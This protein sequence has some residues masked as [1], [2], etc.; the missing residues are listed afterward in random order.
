MR[1]ILT[2]LTL[3]FAGPVFAQ[4]LYSKS[5]EFSA[6][7]VS[8]AALQAVLDKA[9][10]LA[11]SANGGAKPEREEITLRARELR[12]NLPGNKLIASPAKV[13][14]QIDQLTYSF[15]GRA[16][17]PIVQLELDLTEYRR[18][19]TVRGS[20]ADQVDALFAAISTELAAMSHPIGGGVLQ[21]LLG[22]PM[23]LT[24][25]L[26]LLITGWN[27]Y[28]TRAVGYGAVAIATLVALVI[29]ATLPLDHLLAGFLGVRGEP[30][31]LVRYGAEISF[32]GL[33]LALVGVPAA[34]MPF[35]TRKQTS[36]SSSVRVNS[37]PQAT[38]DL[39]PNEPKAQNKDR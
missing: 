25:S 14:D 1:T 18:T 20:S 9:N 32:L 11:V 6:L 35:L 26:V 2:I 24:L 12:I 7:R 37:K 38:S 13:P 39:S 8:Y 5:T 28:D 16:S 30:S 34:V 21:A 19:L 33:L 29:A 10:A 3:I 31:A 36:I 23:L 22:L 4:P 15:A 27:W 17:A